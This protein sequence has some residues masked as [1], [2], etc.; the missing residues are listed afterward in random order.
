MNKFIFLLVISFPVIGYSQT[1]RFAGSDGVPRYRQILNLSGE[2]I[3]VGNNSNIEGTPFLQPGWAFGIVTLTDGSVFSDSAINYSLSDGKLFV[4]RNAN[5]YSIKHPVKEFLIHDPNPAN[6]SKTVHFQNGYPAIK[7][8]DATTFYEVLSAGQS[9]Q[10]LKWKHKKVEEINNYGGPVQSKYS[11]VQ[12]FFIFDP[13]ENKMLEF[14]TSV[15]LKLLTKKLPEY[16]DKIL[17]YSSAHK[18]NLKK[19]EDLIRL[20]SFLDKTK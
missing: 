13:K 17:E 2:A 18:L 10:L 19:D 3:P 11:L 4:K 8:K 14:G 7:K 15:G 20:F 6:E 9:M 16:T 5:I 1:P 12:E